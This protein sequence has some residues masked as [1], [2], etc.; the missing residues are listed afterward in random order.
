MPLE[1]YLNPDTTMA[2]GA[3]AG[4]GNAAGAADAAPTVNF[5]TT[6]EGW[7]SLAQD[8]IQ[9]N[10]RLQDRQT[11]FSQDLAQGLQEAFKYVTI[12]VPAAAAATSTPNSKDKAV[13][14][15]KPPTF[16][17]SYSKTND[18]LNAVTLVHQADPAV[19]DTSPN[20]HTNRILVTLSHMTE[21][22]AAPWARQYTKRIAKGELTTWTDFL[23]E[24]KAAFADP[25][26]KGTAQTKLRALKQGSST[27]DEYLAIFDTY[28][29]DSGLGD[30]ALWGTMRENLNEALVDSIYRSFPFPADYE[31]FKLRAR[32]L[33]RNWRERQAEKQRNKVNAHS[34]RRNTSVSTPTTRTAQ[35]TSHVPTMTS[36]PPAAS[37]STSN[38]V[39]PMDV[40][41]TRVRGTKDKNCFIC[42]QPGHLARDCPQKKPVNIRRL[43]EVLSR[44]DLDQLNTAMPAE[45]EEGFSEARE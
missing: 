7:Q 18:F 38:D 34:D 1:D 3:E 39:V 28:A 14:V 8:L 41:R 6:I 20:R 35:V 10:Q 42:H 24:F 33:D 43:M 22:R 31:G 19:F 11:R 17:G 37:S 40:D 5:P 21:G 16:D 29:A 23:K 4:Q 15:A 2:D 9:E 26:P 44:A 25:N 30:E 13:K 27:C 12:N 45:K 32:L 36:A